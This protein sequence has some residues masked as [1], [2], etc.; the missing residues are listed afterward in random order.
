MTVSFATPLAHQTGSDFTAFANSFAV[1][2]PFRQPLQS[3]SGAASYADG[4]EVFAKDAAADLYVALDGTLSWQ[5]AT[6]TAG[7]QLILDVA[8]S[9]LRGKG[10]LLE[11]GMVEA[12]PARIV[13]DNV[14]K[15]RAKEA[16]EALF[17]TVYAAAKAKPKQSKGWHPAMKMQTPAVKTALRLKTHLDTKKT[18]AP[19]EITRLVDD[20]LADAPTGLLPAI[21][22]VAGDRVG[23]AAAYR[24]GDTPPAPA[25]AWLGAAGDA[26]RARRLTWRTYDV[27]GQ[28]INPTY[29]LYYLLRQALQ[30]A[31]SRVVT[32]LTG[33]ATGGNLAHP[34]ATLLP[35]LQGAAPPRAREQV[36]GL[37]R[38]PTSG[39]LDY[40]G[41][42][43]DAPVSKLEWRY[44]DSNQL[45]ARTRTGQTDTPPTL[46]PVAGSADATQKVQTVT[47]I[48]AENGS[49]IRVISEAFQIPC[50]V[51]VALLGTES[52]GDERAVRLEPLRDT[53][54]TTLRGSAAAALE[55][56]YDK[57]A[58]S[59][60]TVSSP[61]D[62]Q[63]GTVSFVLTLDVKQ[64]WDRDVLRARGRRVYWG[65]DRLPI[66]ANSVG[67]NTTAPPIKR[68]YTIT[69]TGTTR[70][71]TQAWVLDGYTPPNGVP[72]PWTGTAAVNPGA[73]LTWDQL[74]QVVDGTRGRRIS[75]GVIQT[76]IS[77][78]RERVEWIQKVA[79]TIFGDLGITAP[80]ATAGGFLRDAVNPGRRGW[81]LYRA[82]SLLCGAAYIRSAYNDS[83]QRT[84]FDLPLVG[85]AY[86]AGQPIAVKKARWG[87]KYH[88]EYVERAGP[89]FNVAAD[90]F[91][92]GTLA[93]APTVRFMR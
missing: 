30:P 1:G 18:D 40:H 88:D 60:G 7:A 70:T 37:S 8:P 6:T 43:A 36:S 29:Y 46:T 21:P 76:L 86:N 28:A 33:V 66:T 61:V 25:P 52:A 41:F 24:A 64:T 35:A 68:Q 72:D 12:P 3:A 5:P 55:E 65:T 39:L 54:R 15:A 19:A 80:P 82:A 2:R 38:I 73:T 56:A 14:D 83:A 84:R 17:Q 50:E 47:T 67:T 16:L 90:L 27:G 4:L 34:L 26:N 74:V 44:N 49:A 81:L 78:A 31:A 87:L 51:L 62:N 53:D 79:P 57:A 58:G 11:L 93:P 92:S 45:E 69:V 71:D 22:V 91:N 42:P 9:A 77:T 63:D 89:F 85:G 23:K 48:W 20:F 59:R 75:P 10:S 13:Y 32:V